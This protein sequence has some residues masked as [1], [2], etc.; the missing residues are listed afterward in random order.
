M[1]VGQ[2]RGATPPGLQGNRAGKIQRVNL[3]NDVPRIGDIPLWTSPP[4]K[5]SFTQQATLTLG[6]YPLTST[7]A[8]MTNQKNLNDSTLLYF[9]DMT[10][11]ADIPLQNYL[12]ALQLSGGG[13]LI[14]KFYI[15]MGSNRNAPQFQDPIVC[16]DYFNGQHFPFVIE[17][18]QTPNTLTAYFEG[19]INQ[20]AAL[21]GRQYINFTFSFYV[22]QITDD[23]FIHAFKQGY[24]VRIF[25]GGS[26]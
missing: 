11:S 4:M 10:F 14:P 8:L 3:E 16:Q 7:R 12:D 19:T 5:F 18:K 17:P 21:A 25:Q 22:T 6:N 20:T 24:P 9:Y 2:Q 13:N 23:N 1:I 15:F 26:F